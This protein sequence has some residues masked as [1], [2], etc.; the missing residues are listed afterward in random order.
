MF[1]A[2]VPVLL[3]RPAPCSALEHLHG[4]SSCF[5]VYLG[6]GGRFF[7][8]SM[9]N[10]WQPC[11]PAAQNPQQGSQEQLP[12]RPAPSAPPARAPPAPG[13]FHL[14][15]VQTSAAAAAA[16][17]SPKRRFDDDSRSSSKPGWPHFESPTP[18]VE[19]VHQPVPLLVVHCRHEKARDGDFHQKLAAMCALVCFC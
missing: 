12:E 11:G 7:L 1:V 17:A 3:A 8:Q 10:L 16:V 5:R 19:M 18:L 9:P 15:H 6:F 14:H 4:C 13:G 2:M